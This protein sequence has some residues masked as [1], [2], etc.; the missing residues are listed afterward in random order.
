MEIVDLVLHETVEPLHR[1]ALL[2]RS[3]ST[4]CLAIFPLTF[5]YYYYYLC[6]YDS[7]RAQVHKQHGVSVEVRGQLLRLVISFCHGFLGPDLGSQV[8]TAGVFTYSA[9][10]PPL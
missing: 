2:T 7:A 9:I 4:T 8:C 1:R 6:A 5:Y 10:F 3:A